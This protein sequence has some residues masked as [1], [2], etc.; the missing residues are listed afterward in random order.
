ME[1]TSSNNRI[2]ITRISRSSWFKITSAGLTIHLDPG[3]AGYFRN[4]G[5]PETELEDKADIILVSHCHKDHLQPEALNMISDTD[6]SIIAPLS[7]DGRLADAIPAEAG[8]MISLKG[9]SIM[10]VNAYNTPEGSSTKKVHHKGDGLGYVLFLSGRAIYFA[11]DTDLIP[12]ISEL[13]KVDIAFLPIGGT[14]VMDI[15]DAVKAAEIIGTGLVIPMHEGK[16]D[17]Q[18]IKEALTGIA[19]VVLIKPSESHVVIL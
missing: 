1:D 7:C 8:K 14:Y 19:P 13:G 5:I 18:L 3:Y 6:T 10:P 16:N 12:E 17:P 2:T 4:Q 15:R 9:V 11:G